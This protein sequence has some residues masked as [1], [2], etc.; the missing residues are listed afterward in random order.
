MNLLPR[1]STHLL[2]SSSLGAEEWAERARQDTAG[3]MRTVPLKAT[4]QHSSGL[5][6]VV[7]Q[8]CYKWGRSSRIG[9]AGFTPT[10]PTPPSS[11]A[12][13][14]GTR[15]LCLGSVSGQSSETSACGYPP[16]SRN[17]RSWEMR[18]RQLC[19]TLQGCRCA[20][21]HSVASAS[22]VAAGQR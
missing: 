6:D 14:I 16:A 1:A 22:S 4:T 10:D 7:I 19:T 11:R 15:V 9:A 12:G 17:Q 8:L 20:E 5:K 18:S 21:T 13:G 2:W 3:V